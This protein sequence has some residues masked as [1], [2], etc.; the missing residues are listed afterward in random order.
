[1][2]AG[3]TATGLRFHALFMK[4][5]KT[6]SPEM[7]RKHDAKDSTGHDQSTIDERNLRKPG[8]FAMTQEYLWVT[9]NRRV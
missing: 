1:M 5:I 9:R 6:R 3:C 2:D 8:C 7:E 4:V